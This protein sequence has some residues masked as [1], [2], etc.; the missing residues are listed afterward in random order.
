MSARAQVMCGFI[1]WNQPD[2]IIQ[3]NESSWH[4]IVFIFTCTTRALCASASIDA[5]AHYALAPL[6]HCCFI[7]C[8]KRVFGGKSLCTVT[9]IM[10]WSAILR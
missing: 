7:Q 4:E 2:N 10:N 5:P 3:Q 8:D 6:P 9:I 1:R